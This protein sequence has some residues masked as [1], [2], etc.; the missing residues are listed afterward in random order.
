MSQSLDKLHSYLE[1]L[2]P[3]AECTSHCRSANLLY[4]IELI[5]IPLA[6]EFSDGVLSKARNADP[7]RPSCDLSECYCIY[8]VIDASDTLG[9]ENMN[10]SLH[11]ARHASP[12]NGSFRSGN[13]NR[14]HA[15]RHAHGEVRL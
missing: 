3:T 5:R 9:F 12:S 14:L 8:S 7:R 4:K 11:S 15:C 10:K 1:W 6:S 2:I 13:L